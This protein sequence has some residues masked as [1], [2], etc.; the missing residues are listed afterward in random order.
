MAPEEERGLVS[1]MCPNGL[2]YANA[3]GTFG[4]VSDGGNWSRLASAAH[5]WALKLVDGNDFF[6]VIIP[7]WRSGL[8]RR[9]DL[10]RVI[11]SS[12]IL[13]NDSRIPL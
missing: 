12:N 1:T 5:S 2:F 3:V 9:W 11:S 4:S 6:Y 13:S 7:G 10:R 8:W